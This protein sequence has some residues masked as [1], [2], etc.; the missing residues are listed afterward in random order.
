[1]MQFLSLE[2][3]GVAKGA[4]PHKLAKFSHNCYS[5][6]LNPTLVLQSEQVLQE[7]RPGFAHSAVG[8]RM[9]SACAQGHL[10]V[11]VK[12]QNPMPGHHRL[13]RLPAAQG[14]KR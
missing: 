9:V 11:L 13:G 3:K 12:E 7:S 10:T 6:N 4:T 5:T 14:H 8:G 1:M 2:G